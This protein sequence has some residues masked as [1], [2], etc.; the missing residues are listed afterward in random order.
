MTR[1]FSQ[2]V[3]VLGAI[4]F[5][6][7]S[8]MGWA[9][10]PSSW[11]ML[12][13]GCK[14]SEPFGEFSEVTSAGGR[15]W[16][17][18][19]LGASRVATS[20]TDS[21]AYGDLY[22]WG[23]PADGH[24]DRKSD[25]TSANSSGDVPGHCRFIVEPNVPKDWRTTQNDNLWQGEAGINNPCP[26]GFRLPTFTELDDELDSWGTEDPAGAFASPLK[27]P[28]AGSRR[29]VDGAFIDAGTDTEGTQG[30][31]WSSTIPTPPG[32]VT[33]SHGL[34]FFALTVPP[35]ANMS[36]KPRALGASVRCIKNL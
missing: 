36:S 14:P 34:G 31:Y 33:N 20:S 9:A 19:N 1:Y 24:Q 7:T 10:A 18:R 27:L 6:L 35:S 29:M 22:Q 16:M 4:V 15:I 23:R 2:R 5:F 32:S 8:G 3:L 25:I 21:E 12:L 17:D 28:M 11:L 26:A 30:R 13:L